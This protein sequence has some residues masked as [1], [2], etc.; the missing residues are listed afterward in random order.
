MQ[1]KLHEKKSISFEQPLG[2]VLAEYPQVEE[3]FLEMGIDELPQDKSINQLAA[4]L[5]VE[6]SVVALALSLYDFEVEGY[7]QDPHAFVNPLP[8][9]LETLFSQDNEAVHAA[10]A[11]ST[12]PMYAHMEEAIKRAQHEGKLPKQ[13]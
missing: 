2:T 7:I 12:A 5:G 11:A 10:A 9:A 8:A 4:D 13:Q 6:S 1:E 3:L